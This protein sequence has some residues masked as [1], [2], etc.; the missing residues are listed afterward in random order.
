MLDLKFKKIV[1]KIIAK[2]YRKEA[3]D[4]LEKTTEDKRTVICMIN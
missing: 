3:L 1:N 2:E 4:I